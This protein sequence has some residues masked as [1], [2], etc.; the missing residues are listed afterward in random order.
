M[1]STPCLTQG[2]NMINFMI[3]VEKLVDEYSDIDD[4]LGKPEG[5]YVFA[6]EDW[7]GALDRFHNTIPIGCLEEVEIS[8]LANTII[9]GEIDGDFRSLSKVEFNDKIFLSPEEANRIRRAFNRRVSKESEMGRCK[10]IW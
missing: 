2:E 4:R 8:Q 7:S 6:A 10:E 5:Y 9:N 3:Q 1:G